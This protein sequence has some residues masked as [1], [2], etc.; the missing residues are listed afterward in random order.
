MLDT[1]H[2]KVTD[3]YH[4]EC[5]TT[6]N[7]TAPAGP[8]KQLHR[9]C[10]A[11]LEGTPFTFSVIVRKYVS[12]NKRPTMAVRCVVMEKHGQGNLQFLPSRDGICVLTPQIWAGLVTCFDPQNAAEVILQILRL[13][14]RKPGFHPHALGIL[15]ETSM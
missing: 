6:V 14:L 3:A 2:S 12:H 9:S 4:S 10:T 7:P 5:V 8:P 15:P 13:G 1:G 11:H